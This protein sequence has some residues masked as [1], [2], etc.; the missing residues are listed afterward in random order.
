MRIVNKD[1]NLIQTL[2]NICDNYIKMKDP[3][4]CDRVLGEI[5][6]YIEDGNE[7]AIID[8]YLLRHRVELLKNNVLAAENS[9]IMALNFANNMEQF[10]RAGEISITLGK[11][12]IE[13]NK[14]IE[15]A[16]YLN[17]GVIIFKKLGILS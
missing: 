2:I 11:F 10:K 16:K 1:K 13:I 3:E 9:L 8:Y 4:N 6:D 5:Y 14:E 12:Y 15:A 17:E 7:G